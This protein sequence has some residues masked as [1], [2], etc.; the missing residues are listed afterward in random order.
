MT[1]SLKKEII[2]KSVHALTVIILVIYW[3]VLQKYNKQTALLTLTGILLVFI[4]FEYIR[5]ERRTHIPMV[6]SLWKHTRRA[7]ERNRFGGDIFI[8]VGSILAL[9]I[10][11]LRI[12]FAVIL[13]TT[14]GDLAAALIGKRFGKTWIAQMQD[15]AWEGIIAE[16]GVNII[17]G[18]IIFFIPILPEPELIFSL[19]PWLI[20]LIMSAVAT[21]VETVIYKI[22]DNL[23][24]PLFAGTAG[25]LTHLLS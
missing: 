2:R 14:F 1:F 21:F 20:I 22:D 3:F 5:I 7:K 15:R 13:M 17:I 10:F 4:I 6:S 8:L 25:Q 9:S 16:F 11:D 24:I 12:A 19:K 18:I 23:V